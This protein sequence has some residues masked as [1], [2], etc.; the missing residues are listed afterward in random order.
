[1]LDDRIAEHPQAAPHRGHLR[2]IL[3]ALV[4]EQRAAGV[5]LSA[6][7]AAG[8]RPAELVG[9][10]LSLTWQQLTTAPAD[11][12]WL[13]RHFA[14]EP[15]ADGEAADARTVEIVDL[16]AGPAV[17]IRTGLLAPV[18]ETT[19]RQR[20]TVSQ[21]V[22]PVPGTRWLGV[23]VVS[24]PNLALSE[25]FARLADDVARSLRFLDPAS[26]EPGT[27]HRPA[28]PAGTIGYLPGQ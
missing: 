4:A 27:P 17:R 16:P 25:V 11:I 3:Q 20:V 24:T 14:A 7:L 21:F 28:A 10:N 23:I 6:V 2:R 15:T 26:G 9:A 19:R 5:F 13:A 1:V 8:S 12:G 18:P 22:I